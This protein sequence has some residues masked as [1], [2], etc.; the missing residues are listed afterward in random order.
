MQDG[1][2]ALQGLQGSHAG[3][4]IRQSCRFVFFF[5]FASTVHEIFIN[6]DRSLKYHLGKTQLESRVLEGISFENQSVKL[7]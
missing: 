3:A 4:N 2:Q 5:L 7:G 1:P 6:E